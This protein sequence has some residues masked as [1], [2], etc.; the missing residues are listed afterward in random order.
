[1]KNILS[2][3]ALTRNQSSFPWGSR[4]PSPLTMKDQYF[5]A[6]NLPQ[7]FFCKVFYILY[8]DGMGQRLVF[9]FYPLDIRGNNKVLRVCP[10]R[11]GGMVTIILSCLAKAFWKNHWPCSGLVD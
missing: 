5:S 4:G 8:F 11:L 6:K 10:G 1:M 7:T 3:N 9:I 2:L